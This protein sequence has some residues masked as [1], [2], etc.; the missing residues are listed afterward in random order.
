[1]N[2]TYLRPLL[3]LALALI[4]TAEGWAISEFNRPVQFSDAQGNFAQGNVSYQ[5]GVFKQNTVAGSTALGVGRAV[6]RTASGGVGSGQKYA[7]NA[8][9]GGFNYVQRSGD[10]NTGSG[11][12]GR[13]F[14]APKLGYTGTVQ[15]SCSGF[16]CSG[17]ASITNMFTGTTQNYSGQRQF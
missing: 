6:N 17:N 16:A 4:A 11:S 5:G 3:I 7:V 10:L 8:M 1:M 12:S 14:Y 13:V 15:V 2:I 9:T